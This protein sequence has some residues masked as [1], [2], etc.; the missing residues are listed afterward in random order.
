[1]GTVFIIILTSATISAGVLALQHRGA[2]LRLPLATL[3]VALVVAVVS[4][5]GEWSPG[6]LAA[7][8][9]DLPALQSGEWWRAVTPLVVQDGG[10][11]GLIFNLCALLAIGALA[12]ALY[13]RWVVPAVFVLT[14]LI[15]ELAAYTVMQG[16][17]FAGNS[18]ANLGLAG[19]VLVAALR[20]PRVPA[21]VAAVIGLLAGVA[22]I[23][24]WDLHS[25]GITVGAVLGV[26]LRRTEGVVLGDASVQR[27]V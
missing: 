14:G 17:G 5:I 21:R 23:V 6:V 10:W 25:V 18:V 20:T 24:T 2:R 19:V 13:P 1:V 8:G 22:L 16:Q 26:L 4:T 15:G 27:Q 3:V 12:E 11:P 7:L 9:R